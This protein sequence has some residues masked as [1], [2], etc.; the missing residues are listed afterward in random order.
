MKSVVKIVG[1][2]AL[3]AIIGLAVGCSVSPDEQTLIT[4]WGLYGYDGYFANVTVY[5]TDV[6]ATAKNT[7]VSQFILIRNGAASQLPVVGP[8]LK[9][10]KLATGAVVLHINDS[11]DGMGD[12]IYKGQTTRVVMLGE[13]EV[14]LTPDMFTP[15]IPDKK[16]AATN[17]GTYT[18][19]YTG[20]KYSSDSDTT[21]SPGTVKETIVLSE[22]SFKISDDARP[23]EDYLMFSITSWE[24]SDPPADA[25]G[26]TGGYKFTGKITEQKN[27]VPSAKTAPNF[28]KATDVKADKSGPDCWMYI[29]FK[30]ETGSITFVRTPFNKEGSNNKGIVT[31]NDSRVRVYT[32]A[33]PAP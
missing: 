9:P 28:N 21:G 2:I 24:P 25:V 33:P 19:E 32:K 20:T 7:G 4:I 15:P 11:I 23:T 30:G 17:F 31:G 29:Y 27:Y 1:I 14:F 5:D 12:T 6:A 8:D 22:T 10:A 26:Y 18:T 13:G 16:P 3:L